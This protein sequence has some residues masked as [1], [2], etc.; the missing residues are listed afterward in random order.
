MNLMIVHPA[1]QNELIPGRPL[2]GEARPPV[3][4]FTLREG[5]S[6]LREINGGA[7]RSERIVRALKGHPVGVIEDGAPPTGGVSEQR[8]AW[9]FID[10]H[11][12]HLPDA[13]ERRKRSAPAPGIP[14]I[15]GAVAV[16]TYEPQTKYDLRNKLDPIG[17]DTTEE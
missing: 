5:E 8:R 15:P 16:Q 6:S 3:L 11:L 2:E 4:V 12:L 17:S 9:L 1:I 13:R 7:I 14:E 10:R